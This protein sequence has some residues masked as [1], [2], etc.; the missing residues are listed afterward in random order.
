MGGA[1]FGAAAAQRQFILI[2]AKEEAT[3]SSL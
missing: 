2:M 3:E 1:A